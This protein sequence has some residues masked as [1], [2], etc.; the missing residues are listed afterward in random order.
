MRAS[1]LALDRQSRL[2]SRVTRSTPSDPRVIVAGMGPLVR[3]A[4]LLPLLAGCPADPPFQ[5]LATLCDALAEDICDARAGG[6][7][8]G[9]DPATC[10]SAELARCKPQLDALAAEDTL[11]YDATEA[12]DK[13]RAARTLLDSCGA[14]PTLASFFTGGLVDGTPCER[15]AQCSGGLCTADTRLCAPAMPALCVAP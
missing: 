15:D 2:P 11:N 6:C 14:P 12:E 10:V 7:C 8:T 9:A 13:R 4:W 3:Y 5:S 1:S